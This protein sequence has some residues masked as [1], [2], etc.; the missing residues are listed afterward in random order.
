[1]NEPLMPLLLL[2]PIIEVFALY[3][4]EEEAAAAAAAEGPITV[5]KEFPFIAS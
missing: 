4:E 1:M 3:A 2:F 5:E